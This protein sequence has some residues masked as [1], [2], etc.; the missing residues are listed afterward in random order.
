VLTPISDTVDAG[1]SKSFDLSHYVQNA[2]NNGAN[3]HIVGAVTQSTG[4]RIPSPSVSGQT[5]TISPPASTHG[6]LTF[7]VKVSDATGA[8]EA[9]RTADGTIT[10]QVA[11]PPAVPTDLHVVDSTVSGQIGLEWTASS[12]GVPTYYEVFEDPGTSFKSTPT[13]TTAS[14]LTNGQTYTF[15]VEG[16]NDKGCSAKSNAVSATPDAV[17]GAPGDLTVSNIGDG[18]LTLNW[19]A[20]PDPGKDAVNHYTISWGGGSQ[21]VGAG[22]LSANITGLNNDVVNTFSVVATNNKGDGPPATVEGQT[23]GKPIWLAGAVTFTPAESA[24]ETPLVTVSWTPP[25]PNGPSPVNYTVVRSGSGGDKTVCD[26]TSAT[27]CT[28]DGLTYDGRTYTYTVT[29]MNAGG[30]SAASSSS[31]FEATIAP[32]AIS[33]T[34]KATGADDTIA[35]SI[36]VPKSNG[37]TSTVKCTASGGGSCGPWTFPVGGE[38][39]QA[40]T[41]TVPANGVSETITLQDCNGS[42]QAST[43]CDAPVSESATAYGPLAKPTISASKSGKTVSFTVTACGNGKDAVASVTSSG[44]QGTGTTTSFHTGINCQTNSYQDANVGYNKTD[45]IAVDVADS[46]R[47]ATN[48]VPETTDSA[49]QIT[50]QS[51]TVNHSPTGSDV[52]YS[53]VVCGNGLPTTATLAS[54]HGGNHSASLG[55]GC[56]STPT[57]TDGSIGYSTTDTITVTASDPDPTNGR[58]NVTSSGSTT[59]VGPPPPP[60]TVSLSASSASANGKPGCSNSHCHFIVV[61]L[62]GFSGSVT[63]SFDSRE[64]PAGFINETFGGNGTYQSFDY[65]GWSG[66]W[67]SASCNGVSSGQQGWP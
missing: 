42:S 47:D 29:A 59:T 27:S 19:T 34:A 67:V 25:D 32:D 55:S 22:G 26:N 52:T 12:Y 16:C 17:P 63:C 18:S 14:G 64:G 62:S 36:D 28:D 9:S 38:P 66:G 35:L 5:V 51:V 45:S 60:Q 33:F 13:E 39:G 37:L 40:E 41:V 20:A 46:P 1:K 30:Q 49:P 53:A 6:T 58:S 54:S 3:L 7:D 21:T 10:L 23:V 43:Q 15:T 8:D 44:G 65:Y 57:Y 24:S 56:V 4:P 2:I 31:G 48:T 50:I 61:T 11:G